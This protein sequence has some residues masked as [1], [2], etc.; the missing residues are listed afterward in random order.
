[1]LNAIE[2]IGKKKT[3]INEEIPFC[4]TQL[5]IQHKSVSNHQNKSAK[6]KV[7][8]LS[9]YI[10]ATIFEPANYITHPIIHAGF[11]GN[12]LTTI[13]SLGMFIITASIYHCSVTQLPIVL[14]RLSTGRAI[15]NF[16]IWP[17]SN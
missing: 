3:I 10:S 7:S 4:N 13:D 6:N 2:Y 11:E 5:T 9:D 15:D 14:G 12:H 1:M 17:I 16:T 8:L